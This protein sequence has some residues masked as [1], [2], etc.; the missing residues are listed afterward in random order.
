MRDVESLFI[1]TLV[2]RRHTYHVFAD[3]SSIWVTLI[4]T[5]GYIGSTVWTLCN[6]LVLKFGYSFFPL[7]L[8]PSLTPSL[9]FFCWRMF[10]NH[11][12]M[13]R[14]HFCSSTPLPESG[15]TQNI[16]NHFY[17]T[18]VFLAKHKFVLV[19]QLYP[20]YILHTRY[21]TGKYYF[22]ISPMSDLCIWLYI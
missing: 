2:T 17:T 20:H 4:F 11:G 18:H 16:Y 9:S 22:E 15:Q 19:L 10:R 7:S 6:P 3:C 5:C 12:S 21:P 8:P 1:A 13:E 14:G